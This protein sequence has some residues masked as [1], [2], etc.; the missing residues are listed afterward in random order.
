VTESVRLVN[1]ISRSESIKENR[2]QSVTPS[3]ILNHGGEKIIVQFVHRYICKRDSL[4]RK[5][6]GSAVP[7]EFLGISCFRLTDRVAIPAPPALLERYHTV[8]TGAVMKT[9]RRT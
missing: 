1:V 3:Q 4:G 6:R 8:D 7:V 5:I 9:Q 2:T